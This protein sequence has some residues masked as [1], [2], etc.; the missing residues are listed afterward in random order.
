MSLI[1]PTTLRVGDTVTVRG[2]VDDLD[3]STFRLQLGE[4]LAGRV[5]CDIND[6]VSVEYRPLAVGDKVC[7][8]PLEAE[9]RAV[10]DNLAWLQYDSGE[11]VTKN[12][13]DLVRA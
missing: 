9:V 1:D 2:T 4:R 10:D 6:I 11:R 8:G 5:W 13:H 3:G 7:I 12:V